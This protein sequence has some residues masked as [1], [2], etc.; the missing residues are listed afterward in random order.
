VAAPLDWGLVASQCPEASALD[1]LERVWLE[2]LVD[3]WGGPSA[4]DLAR[5]Y[6]ARHLVLVEVVAAR[7]VLGPVSS[8]TLGPSTVATSAGGELP[9]E[10]WG[11]TAWGALYLDERGAPGPELV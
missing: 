5:L 8:E 2:Q 3:R 10:H 1:A 9:P 7:G 6:L 11:L 4:S